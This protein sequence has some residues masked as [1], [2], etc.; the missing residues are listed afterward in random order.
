MLSS[1]ESLQD[2][3]EL[4]ERLLAWIQEQAGEKD[5]YS[6]IV[7]GAMDYIARNYGEKDLSVAEIAEHLRFS[8]A[9]LNVLFKQEKKVTVKQYLSAYRLERARLFLEQGFYRVNEIAER[10]GYA[11]ANY[12]AKVFRDATGMTP[13]EYR[14]SL[15]HSEQS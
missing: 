13:A 3:Q 10:C 15:G 1:M 14:S 5:G 6:R 7:Q 12:F 2:I 9:Y 4:V 8:Q 11:N